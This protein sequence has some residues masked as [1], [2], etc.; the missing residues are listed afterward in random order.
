MSEPSCPGCADRDAAR[1]ALRRSVASVRRVAQ[2]QRRG[3]RVAGPRPPLPLLW[4]RHPRGH[5]RRDPGARLWPPP[6]S[7]PAPGRACT[8]DGTHAGSL[9]GHTRL[10][11]SAGRQG[12]QAA[13]GLRQDRRTQ[14][15][16]Q[17]RSAFQRV[18]SAAIGSVLPP[19]LSHVPG[20]LASPQGSWRRHRLIA[21]VGSPD[22]ELACVGPDRLV[23]RI[24]RRRR[25][26]NA[27][28]LSQ[29]EDKLYQLGKICKSA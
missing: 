8:N 1:A 4:S 13:A 14:H 20:P 21:V 10:D 25:G 12:R 7:F 5:P 6:G 3:H 24:E 11:G 19:A 27:E 26:S 22:G 9:V 23:Y 17:Q 18:A 15:D 2:G 28:E 29:S 16:E